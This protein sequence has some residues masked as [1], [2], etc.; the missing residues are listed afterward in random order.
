MLAVGILWWGWRTQLRQSELWRTF[1]NSSIERLKGK[2]AGAWREPLRG[3]PDVSRCA[4]F[5]VTLFTPGLVT[6]QLESLLHRMQVNGVSVFV[7]V[8]CLWWWWLGQVTLLLFLAP[9]KYWVR[10]LY[11][12]HHAGHM[13]RQP[14]RQKSILIDG[15][16]NVN[17]IFTSHDISCIKSNFRYDLHTRPQ[18]NIFQSET[19]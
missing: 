10:S 6:R 16:N 4:I 19:L 11:L 1:S 15:Y 12:M 17:Y 14:Y 8:V 5:P 7:D 9:C 18:W 2:S 3:L 13:E